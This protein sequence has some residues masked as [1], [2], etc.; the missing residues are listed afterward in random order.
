MVQSLDFLLMVLGHHWSGLSSH[1]W[2]LVNIL[3]SLLLQ[4]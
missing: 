3:K 1:V 4:L 2:E